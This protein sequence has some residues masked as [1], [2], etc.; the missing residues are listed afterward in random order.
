MILKLYYDNNG[1]PIQY[2]TED[3]DG[4]YIEVD[5]ETFAT[6]PW[7]VQV[8]NGGLVKLPPKV[9][10]NRLMPSDQGTQCD[11]RD[12]AVIRD[13]NGQHWKRKTYED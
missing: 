1:C 4:N 2:T 9:Y 3:L 8:V 6:T 12:V 5:A 7:N 10:Y 11:P 13:A